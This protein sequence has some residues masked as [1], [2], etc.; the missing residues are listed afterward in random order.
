MT[1]MA[2]ATVLFGQGMLETGLT[3]DIPT[4]LL[5]DE[6]LDYVFRMLAGFKVDADTLS[7]DLITEI[8]SYGTYLAEEDT[9]NRMGNFST[10]KL[11]NRKSY[12]MWDEAGRPDIVE[13]ARERAIG[14]LETHKQDNPLSD[15]KIKAIRQV[16]MDYEDEIGV[17]K[18]WEGK[19]DK[20]FI[21]NFL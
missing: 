16:V 11:M 15:D 12:P 6:A 21:D 10:Y 9:L 20:R 18:F 8:G 19:E 2:G 17:S 1:A 7:V 13:L 4:L 5:D 3:W 14:I